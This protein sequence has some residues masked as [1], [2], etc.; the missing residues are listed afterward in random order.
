MQLMPSTAKSLNVNPSDPAQN[1][2]GGAHYLQMQLREFGNLQEALA[3]YNAGPG[4]VENKTWSNIPETLNYV[5]RVPILINKYERIW[6]ENLLKNSLE[7][8]QIP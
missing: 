4:N 6:S 8:K 7:W 5:Q 3:A 1:I 2:D